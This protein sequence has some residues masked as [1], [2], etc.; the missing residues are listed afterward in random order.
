MQSAI[1]ALGVVGITLIWT[2]LSVIDS[3]LLWFSPYQLD[4]RLV[5]PSDLESRFSVELSKS[6]SP[7]VLGDDMSKHHDTVT[8]Q[9]FLQSA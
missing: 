4:L 9:A 6:V 8:S 1:P 5:K 3:V 2:C 7:V